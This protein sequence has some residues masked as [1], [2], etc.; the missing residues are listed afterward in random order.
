L[1]PLPPPQKV[2]IKIQGKDWNGGKWKYPVSTTC[3][4]LFIQWDIPLPSVA[5]PLTVG[6]S[7]SST[8]HC[9]VQG[10]TS[11]DGEIGMQEKRGESVEDRPSDHLDT[12]VFI[13]HVCNCVLKPHQTRQE[14][15]RPRGAERQ[16]MGIRGGACMREGGREDGE[17]EDNQQLRRREKMGTCMTRQL[18]L[19]SEGDRGGGM[20]PELGG[21]G[22]NLRR[23]RRLGSGAF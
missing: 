4:N 22:G 15:G 10:L 23:G 2:N 18:W 11:E 12:G 6:Q 14:E 17:S 16:A 8:L 7:P 5:N 1:P 19:T 9:L 20:T 21:S 13:L 3:F